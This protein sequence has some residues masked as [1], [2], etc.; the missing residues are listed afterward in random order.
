M[1]AGGALPESL[2]TTSLWMQAQS[3]AFPPLAEDASV[4]VCVIGAGIAGLTTALVLAE[5]G[6]SVLVLDDGAIGSGETGRTTAHLSN[7]VDDRYVVIERL[8]GERGAALCADSHTAAI[9]RIEAIVTA[10]AIDCD[11]ERVDGYLFLGPGQDVR[12]LERELD[13]ARAAGLTTVDLFDTA[14]V[15]GFTTGPCLRFPRQAQLHPLRYLS[16]LARAV[17]RRGGRIRTG[18][19]VDDVQDGTPATVR[20]ASGRTVSAGSVVVATN[21][22]ANDRFVIHTKQAAYRTYVVGARVPAGRISHALFWD[23]CD[24]YHYIRLQKLDGADEEILIVGGED[25]K[26][27]QASDTIPERQARLE[28][29]A[30]EHFPMITDVAYRWSGQVMEPVDRVAFIG[31]NPGDDHIY[32]ATGDSGMG[33]TH[34]TIAGLLIPDLI[35]GKD[36]RWTSLYDP[37][38]ITLRSADEFLKEN[39]NVAARYGEW[40]AA[41]DVP[42]EDHIARG[43]GA[44]VRDGLAKHAVYRDADGVLHRRSAVC[45]HLGCVVAWNPAEHSWDCPCHGSR[46][47]PFGRVLNGP[48]L[49]PLAE[50]TEP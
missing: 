18:T 2:G 40:L 36:N 5:A 29:W 23:T 31:R 47:D 25:H 50:V 21:T 13:A 35:L 15:E 37:G 20:T 19:H 12:L 28:D 38:R 24:P 17:E 26:T 9:D 39:V 42:S 43:T 30:R 14:P 1:T 44:I 48:A 11:F 46:F 7:A 3:P 22:P 33:M 8:H 10:E 34:G 32:V 41:G 6:R 27:G 16:G 49:T 4:D 45:P